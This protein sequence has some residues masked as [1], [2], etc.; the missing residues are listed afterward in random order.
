LT[1]TGILPIIGNLSPILSCWTGLPDG[2]FSN[3]KSKFV[4]ILEGLALED[5]DIFY[6]YLIYFT[7][8]CHILWPFGIF[9]GNLVYF[10]PFW[11]ARKIWQPWLLEN[12]LVVLTQ[13]L[14]LCLFPFARA[15]NNF[16]CF[17]FSHLF[18]DNFQNLWIC[19]RVYFIFLRR[20]EMKT[21]SC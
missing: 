12:F 10:V 15:L 18:Y 5:V 17:S 13:S 21:D 1:E 3:K 8:I 4:L 7:A 14:A 20:T 16:V 19:R 2:I 11:Y 9:S 6:V